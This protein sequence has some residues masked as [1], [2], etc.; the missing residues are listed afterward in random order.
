MKAAVLL[1]ADTDRPDGMGRMVNALTTAREF[2][3]NGD[4]VVVIFDG[5][6]VKWIPELVASDHKYHRLFEEVRDVVS[7]ACVYCSRAFGV[8]DAVE[9]AGIPFLDE[10][11][12]HPS[13]RSL[14]A[15]GHQL[16]TF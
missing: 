2:Q 4:E 3:E 11:R 12:G 9:K 7:G 14:M 6:G 8:K 13:I 16:I 1:L 15:S 5:I 10:F